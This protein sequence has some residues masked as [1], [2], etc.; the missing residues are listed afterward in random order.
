MKTLPKEYFPSISSS[1]TYNDYLNDPENTKKEH[2]ELIK[3]K[4]LDKE[5][6]KIGVKIIYLPYTKS[7]SST[8]INKILN[9]F[10]K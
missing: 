10:R 1:H 6:S 5:F 4:N 8:K 9:K 2:F 3:W 7:T